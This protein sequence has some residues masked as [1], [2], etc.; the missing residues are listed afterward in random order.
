MRNK[1]REPMGKYS[2]NLDKNLVIFTDN[3]YKL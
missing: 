3:K 1:L 2:Q